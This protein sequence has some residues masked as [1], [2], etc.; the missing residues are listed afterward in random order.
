M[1]ASAASFCSVR[2][3]PFCKPGMWHTNVTMALGYQGEGHIHADCV[4][5]DFGNLIMV[6]VYGMT[7]GPN[8]SVITKGAEE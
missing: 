4:V 5:D 6:N 7:D 8:W 2:H 3:A 1:S